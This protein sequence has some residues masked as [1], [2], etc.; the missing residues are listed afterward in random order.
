M[1][2]E[3]QNKPEE[4]QGFKIDERYFVEFPPGDFVKENEEGQLYIDV[5]VYE[6]VD[7]E[8]KRLKSEEI[9]EELT[10]KINEAI[11]KILMKAVEEAELAHK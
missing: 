4:P 8:I 6:N 5:I 7:D 3:D 9:S 10:E 2:Q 11:N 1:T